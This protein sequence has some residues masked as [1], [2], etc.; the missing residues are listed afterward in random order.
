MSRFL[1]ALVAFVFLTVPSYGAAAV[2]IDGSGAACA[3]SVNFHIVDLSGAVLGDGSVRP[4]E[5]SRGLFVAVIP[6]CDGSV[7][8]TC[9][10]SVTLKPD[11][12]LDFNISATNN[13]ASDVVF[14][15][16]FSTPYIG[17]PYLYLNSSHS[18][19]VTNG[20]N[21]VVTVTPNGGAFLQVP[22]LDGIPVTA[23]SL[24]LGCALTAAP[25]QVKLCEAYQTASVGV[26]SLGS[27]MLS[28]TLS[29]SLSPGDTYQALGHVELSNSA[30]EPGTLVFLLI[31]GVLL[32][33]LRLRNRNAFVMTDTELNVIAADAIIGLKSSPK[34]G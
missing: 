33:S 1:L 12:Y 17:G 5:I 7:R 3:G 16:T 27:G 31:G 24:G 20:A 22:S 26:N 29:F 15:F 14:T 28:A 32:Y 18:S 8:V 4:T 19:V 10:G 11:P 21:E 13:T 30:P 9:D 2:C 34:N 23:A 25:N 6:Q